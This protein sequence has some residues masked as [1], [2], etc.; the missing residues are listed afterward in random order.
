M[1]NKP[2][3]KERCFARIGKSD[4]MSLKATWPLSKFEFYDDHIV[5]QVFIKK[6]SLKFNE[7]DNVE[8]YSHPVDIGLGTG[9]KINHHTNSSPYVAFWPKKISEV[10]NLFKEKKILIK[11]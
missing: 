6:V 5:I 1:T 4:M 11:N 8:K 10:I 7:I 3:F 9:I 2:L